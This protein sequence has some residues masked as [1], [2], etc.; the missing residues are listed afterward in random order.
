LLLVPTKLGTTSQ[1]AEDDASVMVRLPLNHSLP[2]ASFLSLSR[3][4]RSIANASM[5]SLWRP[6]SAFTDETGFVVA[7]AAAAAVV[8]GL[9]KWHRGR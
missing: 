9:K 8:S 4:S 1:A 2:P 6:F 5:W 7:A 3:S